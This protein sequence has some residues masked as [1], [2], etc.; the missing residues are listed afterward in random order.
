MESAAILGVQQIVVHAVTVP[1]DA[2]VSEWDYNLAFYRSL[3]PYCDRFGIR[4]AVEN[5]FKWDPEAKAFV[6][7]IGTPEALCGMVRAL[8]TDRFVACVDIGHAAL[9]GEE[10]ERFL[11]AMD[12]TLLKGLHV[13]DGDY[14]DDGHTLPYLGRFHWSEIL[15]ALREKKY[16]GDITF[17]IFGYFRNF[18]DDLLPEALRMAERVGR[19]MI[20]ELED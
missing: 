14:R 12:G 13:Q 18:P 7:R 5:L 4:I 2:D 20:A 9:I 6:G 16:G 10:P 8:G 1:A 3:A 17:E 19:Q 11:A 15:R